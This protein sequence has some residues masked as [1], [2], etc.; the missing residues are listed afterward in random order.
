MTTTQSAFSDVATERTGSTSDPGGNNNDYRAS[1]SCN[2]T[3]TAGAMTKSIKTTN[4]ADTTGSNVAIGEIVTYELVITI[5][6]GTMPAAKVTDTLPAGLAFKQCDSIVNSNPAQ[7]TT[8]LGAR[9]QRRLQR[10]CQ[11][12]E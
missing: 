5:P 4:L 2:V 9:L 3:V 1:G 10:R 7:V 11:L 12:A 8:T 6:E